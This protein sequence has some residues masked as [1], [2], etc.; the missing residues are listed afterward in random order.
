MS[1]LS[2]AE[3]LIP[4]KATKVSLKEGWKD[5][6]LRKSEAFSRKKNTTGGYG[7]GSG[8]VSTN[9]GCFNKPAPSVPEL[10]THWFPPKKLPSSSYSLFSSYT[11]QVRLEVFKGCLVML[12]AV[13]RV[14]RNSASPAGSNRQTK[15][16]HLIPEVA[17]KTQRSERK[18]ERSDFPVTHYNW[19]QVII[20]SSS[21]NFCLQ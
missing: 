18:S 11:N 9:Q 12:A 17:E 16:L 1:E 15:L 6:L 4:S 5:N 2:V 20:H 21:V 14:L 7:T 10:H 13:C 3:S 19:V 8:T